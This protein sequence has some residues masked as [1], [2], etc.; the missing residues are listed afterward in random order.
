[1]NVKILIG[2]LILTLCSISVSAESCF[3]LTFDVACYE[4]CD[5]NTKEMKPSTGSWSDCKSPNKCCMLPEVKDEVE[6]T[7]TEDYFSLVKDNPKRCSELKGIICSKGYTCTGEFVY[8]PNANMSCCTNGTCVKQEETC[9]LLNGTKCNYNEEC[10]GG[11]MTTADDSYYCCLDGTCTASQIYSLPTTTCQSDLKGNICFPG[12]EC[13]GG[14]FIYADDS[15][16]CCTGK[17]VSPQ[18]KAKAEK[19]NT[20]LIIIVIILVIAII[21]IS[22]Y[23]FLHKKK[24]QPIGFNTHSH[25]HFPPIRRKP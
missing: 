24:S 7:L 3:N 2:I 11:T 1:M 25:R 17:C 10:K 20:I 13:K 16:Y 21:T 23:A 18:K 9:S 8:T 15:S 4:T 19:T 6:D 12:E 22:T 5:A 14:S